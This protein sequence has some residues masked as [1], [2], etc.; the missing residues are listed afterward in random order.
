MDPIEY[1][2][3]YTDNAAAVASNNYNIIRGGITADNGRLST[4]PNPGVNDVF[5][6]TASLGL[7]PA[8]ALAAIRDTTWYVPK[9][10]A[11][12]TT[13]DDDGVESPVLD[14]YGQPVYPDREVYF[15][16]RNIGNIS[17][18]EALF[19]SINDHMAFNILDLNYSGFKDGTG[20]P[21]AAIGVA[22]LPTAPVIGN[23]PRTGNWLLYT[24]YS[25]TEVE[26]SVND[27]SK[28]PNVDWNAAVNIG[29]F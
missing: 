13:I 12:I 8:A 19:D 18:D 17:D 27:D 9:D 1:R 10:L 15:N 2:G 3:S 4:N 20:V 11:P 28:F 24:P 22:A 7:T 5:S 23:N 16:N 6:I 21:S 26:D 14:Q 29:T 25:N